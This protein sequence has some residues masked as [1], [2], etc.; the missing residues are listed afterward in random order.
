MEQLHSAATGVVVKVANRFNSGSVRILRHWFAA[1]ERHP[2][3]TAQDVEILQSKT[4]LTK[5]QV[6]NW[7]ANARRRSKHALSSSSSVVRGGAEA[8]P[9]N[10][11]PVDIPPRAATPMP[12]NQMNPL[13]RWKSSPP[14]HEAAEVSDICRAVAASTGSP[15]D[16]HHINPSGRSS[17]RNS[18]ASSADLSHSSAGS[19]SQSSAYSHN[20]FAS[21][22][23][24]NLHRRRKR[25]GTRRHVGKQRMSSRPSLLRPCH[26]YQ[27]TFCIETFKHKYDWQRHEKSLHLSLEE[28]ICS[29]KGSTVINPD[30]GGIV[31]VYCGKADPDQS[32]LDSHNHTVCRDRVLEERTF[33]RK[34]HLQQHLKLVHDSKFMKWPMDEWKV[35]GQDIRSRCGFCGLQLSS[36]ATRTEHLAEHF[37][38][39]STMA[40]WKGDWGFD[41]QVVQNI[42]NAIPPYLIH[43][44]QNSPFPISMMEEPP[45]T[46]T[47]AYELIKLELEYYMR[48]HLDAKGHLPSDHDLQYESCCIIFGADVMSNCPAASAPSWLRDVFMCSEVSKE[49]RLR[50]M[51]QVT[52]SRMSQL[53]I[54]SKGAIFDNCELELELCRFV[55]MHSALGLLLSDYELQQESSNIL[56]AIE[57]FSPNPS[58]HFIDF[59]LRLVW[60]SNQWLEP[61][62]QRGEQ[63][64]ALDAGNH[65]LHQTETAERNLVAGEFDPL[66]TGTEP[67]FQGNMTPLPRTGHLSPPVGYNLLFSALES[68]E[69]EKTCASGPSPEQS[70][71]AF[72]TNLIGSGH[73]FG[74]SE[75]PNKVPFLLNDHN[76]YRR[77]ASG[78][79]RFVA[80]TMSPNN[81]NSHVPTDE[82]LQYQARW[83]WYDDD[84]PWNQTPADNAEWLN[85]FKRDVGLLTNNAT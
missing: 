53:K 81:P 17:G 29:P 37:K 11:T 82:E 67:E 80:T 9:N 79:S 51:Q 47:S 71:S 19:G 63:V 24:R 78:L 33:Y 45:D 28:W 62:R 13:E 25:G 65:D 60:G 5:Q 85:E 52:K 48:D 58:K 32:H 4:G 70:I 12:S 7:L 22:G 2:Y 14:E 49:A 34:D 21:F 66:R 35:A 73:S 31:C 64:S 30:N 1:H 43:Y 44:E 16:S 72:A 41:A 55:A 54:N 10:S 15:S 61:L 75:T 76:S 68:T 8:T 39:G 83:I 57:A 20:S 84:D 27:C 69:H 23:T 59:V 40:D 38:S 42:D 50:P 56:A 3:A 36:W 74:G 46:P 6:A 18:S 77:L 26:M